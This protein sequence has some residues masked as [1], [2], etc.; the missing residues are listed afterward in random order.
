MLYEPPCDDAVRWKSDQIKLGFKIRPA[1]GLHRC[2]RNIGKS[3]E[4]TDQGSKLK[5]DGT[6]LCKLRPKPKVHDVFGKKDEDCG[7]RRKDEKKILNGPRGNVR[8]FG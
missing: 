5:N 8:D 7:G 1:E 4:E 6:P 3:V 2:V